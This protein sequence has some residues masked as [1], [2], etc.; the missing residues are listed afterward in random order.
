MLLLFSKQD[1]VDKQRE[2][3]Q[4]SDDEGVPQSQ[5]LSASTSA[6]S[7]PD[8]TST[9]NP[10]VVSANSSTSTNAAATTDDKKKEKGPSAF[11]KKFEWNE[12]VR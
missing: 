2:D 11:R 7:A 10:G 12:K 5:P 8:D 6:G 3:S 4:D 9:T 1:D